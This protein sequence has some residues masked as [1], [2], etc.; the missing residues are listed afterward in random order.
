MCLEPNPALID[1]YVRD[2]MPTASEYESDRRGTED[3][4]VKAVQN[5][6]ALY[7]GQSRTDSRIKHFFDLEWFGILSTPDLDPVTAVREL[8]NGKGLHGPKPLSD[9]E[10]LERAVAVQQKIDEGL[11][12]EDAC[13]S[14][15]G[16]SWERLR[17]GYYE[18]KKRHG[19]RWAGT[20]RLWTTT[21]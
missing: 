8:F 4:R 2:A 16:L 11:S 20:V 17:D 19:E 12:I 10:R 1:I 3:R 14:V 18:E 15:G 9:D 5:L 6:L 21:L 7:R 13:R